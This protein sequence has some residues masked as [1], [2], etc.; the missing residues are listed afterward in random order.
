[1]CLVLLSD[2]VDVTCNEND[3]QVQIDRSVQNISDPSVLSLIN[4][5]CQ[6]TSDASYIN[7]DITLGTCGTRVAISTDG[8]RSFYRNTITSSADDT[9]FEIICSYIREP[10]FLGGGEY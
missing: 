3:I 9:E 2:G 1:M 4:S 7:F 5:S 10:T 8:V 6:A